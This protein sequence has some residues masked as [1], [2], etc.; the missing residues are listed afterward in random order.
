[1]LCK[2]D[3]IPGRLLREGAP[4]LAEPITKLFTMSLQSG[5]L[6]RDWRRANV[7]TVFKRGNK[8]SPSNYHPITLTSVVVKCLERLVHVRITEFLDALN[9]HQ[10]GF[11]KGHS[12]QTQLL[13]TAH[14]WAKSLDRGVST[15][16][17][18]LDF[19]KAFDSVRHQRVLM[20]LDCMGDRGNLLRWIDAYLRDREQRVVVEDQSSD[21]RKVT[22]GVPRGP[23]L[24][25]Y[26]FSYTSIISTL[27]WVHQF[28]SL[29]MTVQS[30]GPFR[31]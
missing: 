12:C 7:T 9:C 17:I 28:V 22:S 3:E 19:S 2:I 18:Y 30:S 8:H 16:V 15:H 4:W 25:L 26:F 31:A 24:A 14:E 13:A 23:F 10:H 20:K 5:F 27:A 1:M 11:R 6:P 21:W 29:Q